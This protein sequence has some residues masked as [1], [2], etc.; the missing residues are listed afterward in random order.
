MSGGE[1]LLEV[2]NALDDHP[3]RGV[4][5][6][7]SAFLG[8]SRLRSAS[9]VDPATVATVAWA[10]SGRLSGH[11]FYAT[12]P[13]PEAEYNL[14]LPLA[15]RK[16]ALRRELKRAADIKPVQI[17]IEELD[18]IA[19]AFAGIGV[20]IPPKGSQRLA[21]TLKVRAIRA[22]LKGEL[23]NVWITDEGLAALHPL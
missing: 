14:A 12:I 21:G 22:A 8:R 23:F 13:P 6:C 1:T 5:F 7:A 19:V 20:V 18:D 2:M 10:R 16:E 4:H 3:R 11:C 17:L 15:E 9:H